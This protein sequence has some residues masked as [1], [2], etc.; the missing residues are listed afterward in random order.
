MYNWDSNVSCI[1]FIKWYSSV[2]KLQLYCVLLFLFIT[3]C[4]RM[5][6]VGGDCPGTRIKYFNIIFQFKQ[7]FQLRNE[8]TKKLDF[9]FQ[10][11]LVTSGWRKMVGNFFFV[12]TSAKQ[13]IHIKK[14]YL[15]ILYRFSGWTGKEKKESAPKNVCMYIWLWWWWR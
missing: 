7:K 12:I 3:Y 6:I 15:H 10:S 1:F 5:C 4:V 8:H 13:S 2:C 14:E 9:S 11:V